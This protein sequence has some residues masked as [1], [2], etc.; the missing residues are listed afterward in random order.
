ME[1]QVSWAEQQA[2]DIPGILCTV[3][4]GGDVAVQVNESPLLGFTNLCSSLSLCSAILQEMGL[5]MKLEEGFVLRT[6]ADDEWS[7]RKYLLEQKIEACMA[8]GGRG[9]L[10]GKGGIDD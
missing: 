3:S 4:R 6:A 8:R 1:L 5:P 10:W 2:R 7:V 9:K